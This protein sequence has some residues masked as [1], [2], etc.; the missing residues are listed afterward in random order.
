MSDDYSRAANRIEIPDYTGPDGIDYTDDEYCAAIDEV[1]DMNVFQ[2]LLDQI[3]IS[4]RLKADVD[5]ALREAL[6]CLCK[7]EEA[8][9]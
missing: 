5:K 9:G 2:E 8:N 7:Q 3:L 1:L 4:N 6:P